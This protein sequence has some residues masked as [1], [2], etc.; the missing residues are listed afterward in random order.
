MSTTKTLD[1]ESCSCESSSDAVRIKCLVDN[2]RL[3]RIKRH[4]PLTAEQYHQLLNT[5]KLKSLK[6]YSIVTDSITIELGE[7]AIAHTFIKNYIKTHP[8]FF[9][10]GPEFGDLNV[11]VDFYNST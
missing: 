7:S 9:R 2:Y 11:K 1:V 5:E 3:F 8:M 6:L 4:Q 10:D